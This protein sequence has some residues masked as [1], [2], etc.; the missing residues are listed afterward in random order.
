MS[1]E[2]LAYVKR[3]A[4][5]TEIK[6]LE[7]AHLPKRSRELLEAYK[8]YNDPIRAYWEEIGSL[9]Q[10]DKVPTDFVYDLYAKWFARNNSSGKAV[11]KTTFIESFKRIIEEDPNWE[12]RFDRN[13]RIRR[14][15]GGMSY[16]PLI[17][18]YEL[19][20]WYNPAYRGTDSVKRAEGAIVPETFRGIVKVKGALDGDDA[21]D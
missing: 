20:H 10:W 3:R 11:G 14:P 12:G 21:E 9:L 8:V 17:V 13:Q 2:V 19:R 6:S 1:P 15:A 7:E 5:E 4:I 16:E 18:E